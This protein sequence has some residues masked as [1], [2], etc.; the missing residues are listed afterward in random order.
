MQVQRSSQ[1]IAADSAAVTAMT[2]AYG[3]TGPDAFAA[4]LWASTALAAP[5]RRASAAPEVH[6]YRDAT[7]AAVGNVAVTASLAPVRRIRPQ[8]SPATSPAL[9]D[10]LWEEPTQAA[11][12]AW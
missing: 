10:W 12:G 4:A 1:S 6:A 11:A 2:P 8:V 9:R 5:Q 3:L 7:G